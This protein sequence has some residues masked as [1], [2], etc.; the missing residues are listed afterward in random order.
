[1][2]SI[3]LKHKPKKGWFLEVTWKKKSKFQIGIWGYNRKDE[4]VVKQKKPN[5]IGIKVTKTISMDKNVKNANTFDIDQA[6]KKW[7]MKTILTKTS[8][9]YKNGDEEEHELRRKNPSEFFF[10]PD[11]ICRHNTSKMEVSEMV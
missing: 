4:N 5:R 11:E 7:N 3:K 1:M 6:T 9:N 10:E 2:S 8:E